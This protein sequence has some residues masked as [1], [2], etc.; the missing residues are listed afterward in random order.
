MRLKGPELDQPVDLG[1]LLARGSS[2]G[3]E[4]PALVAAGEL[5]TYGRLDDAA[6]RLAAAW[7]ERGLQP[8]DRVASLMPNSA[9]LVIHYL[10]CLRA[11]LVATPLNYRYAAPEIDHALETSGAAILVAASERREEL[12]RSRSAGKLPL[13][14]VWHEEGG[15]GELRTA[16]ESTAARALPAPDAADT[17]F[18]FFTSG[19][20][21]LPKGVTHTHAT[22]GWMVAST[23]AAFDLV[24]GEVVLPATSLS[25][26]AAIMF[27]L[28]ALAAGG[29][30]V[31][32]RR[33]DGDE[34]LPLLRSERPA[35]LVMLPAALLSLV[36]EH[37]AGRDDFASVRLCVCG[38]DKV[39]AELEREYVELTG[40]RID[41]GY[42]MTEMGMATRNPIDRSVR[43]G[44]IGTVCPGFAF[45]LR[46]EAG[47]AV[48]AGEAGRAWVASRSNMVGYWGAPEATAE[49]LRDGW[50]DTGDLM[51]VDDDGYLWFRGRM[52]QL[53][54]H[55]GSNIAPQEVEE[56]LL[57]H[58]Q[59]ASAGV[60][61]VRD[62][63]HGETV[64]AYV[65]ARDPARPPAA[66]AL[67]EFARTRI[68]A[69]KAPE[70]I[71][72]LDEM[73]LNAAGKVDR[74]R[75]KQL[76]RAA[77]G[78]PATGG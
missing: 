31:V 44:S 61:G 26:V 42:G 43:E 63:F 51:A 55:D 64:R 14:V 45:E 56:A 38:G 28:A 15:S 9:A 33:S 27:G 39:S 10:A 62:A 25:H 76:G 21:G 46:D 5:W 19:S 65:V 48:A 57:E 29:C 8:G 69:Y 47:A 2:D 59:V 77:L 1:R 58:P 78:P 41:E 60:I 4:R 72:F 52:K 3:A 22:F 67:I 30:A 54:I 34:L 66:R 24:P 73:P 37:D 18:I 71:V 17:A 75:L 70:D 40:S 50:L 13:G 20:T 32:P 68:A 53:I 36:R 11:G 12:A 49:V 74:V 35:M 7:L 23:V 16:W 6:A